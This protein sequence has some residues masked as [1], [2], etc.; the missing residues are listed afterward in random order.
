MK[1]TKLCLKCRKQFTAYRSRHR[2]YCS[3]ACYYEAMWGKL[4]NCKT[5]GGKLNRNQYLYCSE[6]CTRKFWDKNA[7]RLGGKKR[8]WKQKLSLVKELGG[9][10]IKCGENDYRVLDINHIDRI[11]KRIPK[12]RHFTLRARLKDWKENKGN[13]EL[14]CANCHRRHTW[15]QMGYG[16]FY[17]SN[18]NLKLLP[19]KH[20]F[21]CDCGKELKG[22]IKQ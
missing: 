22:R 7:Y 20:Q 12:N 5:C 3:Y 13:L 19:H 4:K 17:L 10:C 9:K 2:K 11:K 21:K 8:S 14:L 15:K 16:K 6:K 1:Q 18:P